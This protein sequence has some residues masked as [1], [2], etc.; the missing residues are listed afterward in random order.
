MINFLILRFTLKV[1]IN[2]KLILKRPRKP[3]K[4]GYE[5]LKNDLM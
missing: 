2:K 1:Y 4:Y 5:N 3:L